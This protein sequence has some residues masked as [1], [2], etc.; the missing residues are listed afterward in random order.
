[1]LSDQKFELRAYGAMSALI[2]SAQTFQDQ[3]LAAQPELAKLDQTKQAQILLLAMLTLLFDGQNFFWDHV[4]ADKPTAERFE[5]FFYT[6]FYRVT[7]VNPSRQLKD[8]RA[9]M[10][11]H[12]ED[13]RQ[14]Y[15]VE[16]IVKLLG[17]ESEEMVAPV[18]LVYGAV[19]KNYFQVLGQIWELPDD[20]LAQT[21]KELEQPSAE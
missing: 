7:K 20:V 13:G 18:G 5:K 10:D 11:E 2:Q 21:K 15:L 17:E 3:A 16:K 12:G 14:T 8:H 19:L 1:M 9:H 6:V 4:I